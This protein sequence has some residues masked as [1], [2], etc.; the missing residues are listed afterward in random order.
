M[1]KL[2][3]TGEN[4]AT[5][6]KLQYEIKKGINSEVILA[7]FSPDGRYLATVEFKVGHQPSQLGNLMLT[8]LPIQTK[9]N[10]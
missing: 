1:L 6:F 3:V 7:D 5:D 10:L 4:L 9:A 2:D 8:L